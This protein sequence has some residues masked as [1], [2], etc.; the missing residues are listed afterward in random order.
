MSE[1]DAKSRE[2][3]ALVSAARHLLTRGLWPAVLRFLIKLGTCS[4]WTTCPL[5][6]LSYISIDLF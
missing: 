2:Y 5:V 6:G 1:A 4:D 3:S